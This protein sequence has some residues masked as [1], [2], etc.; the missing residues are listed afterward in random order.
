MR[1]E[2]A[3]AADDLSHALWGGAPVDPERARR[4][5]GLAR[6][7]HLAAT[8]PGGAWVAEAGGDF[9]GAALAIVR[10]GVWGLSLLIVD[11]RHQGR[12]I[13][14]RLFD[15]SLGLAAG[16]RGGI[17]LSSEHPAAM[18]SYARAGFAL[19]PSV[20]ATGVVAAQRIPDDAGRVVEVGEDGIAVADAIGR[21]VRGAGHGRDLPVLLAH[22]ARLLLLD[23][24][25]FVVTAVADTKVYL[26]A[27]RD[28]AAARTVLWAALASAGSGATVE[29]DVLTAA[30]QWAI[31]TCLAAGLALSPAGPLFVRGALGPMAPY[32]PSGAYL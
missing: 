18:H 9:A 24:R 31:E 5:R 8:D 15:A 22:G 32:L 27:A 10:E 16:A 29:V 20:T 30:Q 4:A 17:I 28:E 14:R 3:E 7:H 12:G 2:D 19:H 26:L 25:A 13:G 6:I 23:D 21:D 11:P 1:L